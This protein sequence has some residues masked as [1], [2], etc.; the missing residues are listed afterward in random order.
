M[1]VRARARGHGTRQTCTGRTGTG[2]D[3]H[4]TDVHGR[5]D[6][7]QEDGDGKDGH[8]EGRTPGSYTQ[9]GRAEGTER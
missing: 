7:A 4:G 2:T 1:Q 5:G 9:V 8:G 6:R 3:V